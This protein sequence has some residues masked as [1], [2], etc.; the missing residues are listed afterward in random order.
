M[1]SYR[2]RWGGVSGY[3]EGT[4][5]ASARREI[6][7][8]QIAEVETGGV[9]DEPEVVGDLV[10]LALQLLLGEVEDAVDEISEVDLAEAVTQIAEHGVAEGVGVAGQVA[11]GSG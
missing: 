3:V 7:E 4:A 6:A 10:E 8:G 5:D 9:E 11:E 2:G 1:G